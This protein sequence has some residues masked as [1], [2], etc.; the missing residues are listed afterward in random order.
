MISPQR[1]PV[2]KKKFDGDVVV[3]V[4]GHDQVKMQVR[5]TSALSTRS[6]ARSTELT[7]ACPDVA[8]RTTE[9]YFQPFLEP[10]RL[11]PCLAL[12]TVRPRRRACDRRKT[13]ALPATG[14]DSGMSASRG[15]ALASR[16]WLR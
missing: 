1:T 16:W 5:K 4:R 7:A 8:W 10:S 3:L 6:S 15:Y 11:G 13:R 14:P 12:P 9:V 2:D